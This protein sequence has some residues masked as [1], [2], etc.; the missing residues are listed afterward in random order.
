MPQPADAVSIS[1]SA[2]TD[3]DYR[4]KIKYGNRV[5]VSYLGSIVQ[6]MLALDGFG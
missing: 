5:Q 2:A 3:A 6:N 4:K 1:P